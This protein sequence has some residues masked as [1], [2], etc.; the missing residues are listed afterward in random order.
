LIA[1]EAGG[2]L[3]G[4]NDEQLRMNVRRRGAERLAQ[5]PASGAA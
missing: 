3:A 5:V 1:L 4:I 2:L